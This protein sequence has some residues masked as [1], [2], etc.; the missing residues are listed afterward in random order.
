MSTRRLRAVVCLSVLPVL[1]GCG[2]GGG[3]STGDATPGLVVR[4]MSERRAAATATTL[5][6]GDVLLAG[7]VGLAGAPLASCDVYDASLSTTADAVRPTGAMAR[8]RARFTT[9]RLPSGQV[10]AVGGASDGLTELFTPVPATPTAGAWAPTAATLVTPRSRHAAALLLDGRVLVVGGEGLGGAALASCE[11]FVAAGSPMA[12]AGPLG[13]ARRDASATVLPDGRV[14]VVGGRDAA[15][16]PLG[17]AE[18]YDPGTDTWTTLASA[19][20]TP[21]ALHG[22]VFLDGGDADPS[23]DRVLVTGGA[24]ADGRG[25]ADAEVFD[26]AALGFVGTVPLEGPG[27]FDAATVRLANGQAAVVGGFVAGGADASGY[28]VRESVVVRLGGSVGVGAQDLPSRRGALAVAAVPSTGPAGSDL[29]VAGGYG[30]DGLP[31]DEVY[32]LPIDDELTALVDTLD[33]DEALAVGVLATAF[34]L[35]QDGLVGGGDVDLELRDDPVHGRTVRGFVG[36][37]FVDLEVD[38]GSVVGEVEGKAYVLSVR[39]GYVDSP[40]FQ[41]DF[42]FAG[43][44]EG[45]MDVDGQDFDFDVDRSPGFVRGWVTGF[46]DEAELRIEVDLDRTD[47]DRSYLDVYWI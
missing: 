11:L 33:D 17:S 26:P 44:V 23:N 36:N 29:V 46:D 6:N 22:A 30:P 12:A 21:R 5:G 18:L 45:D 47:P 37:F 10:L 7:G 31:Q 34:H 1:A 8:A 25:V 24:G 14:L 15:G 16:A 27:V 20:T 19:L 28:P 42:R 32:V 40:D 9:T 43:A 2:G 13:T 39:G 38:A 4:A 41:V 35:F 3:D